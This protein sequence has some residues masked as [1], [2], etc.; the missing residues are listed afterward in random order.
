MNKEKTFGNMTFDEIEKWEKQT[1]SIILFNSHNETGYAFQ[2]CSDKEEKALAIL[3]DLDDDC[4]ALFVGNDI[5][6]L[7]EFLNKNF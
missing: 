2:N 1:N 3:F 7:K 4:P 5:L 6:R